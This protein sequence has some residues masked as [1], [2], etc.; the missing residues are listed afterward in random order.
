[1]LPLA[2]AVFVLA[3][4]ILLFYIWHSADPNNVWGKPLSTITFDDWEWLK[5][6]LSKEELDFF[7][8]KVSAMARD[9]YA[10]SSVKKVMQAFY[11]SK[12]REVPRHGF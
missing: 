10:A 5:G 6:K 12:L 11:E 2:I 3:L 9:E 1:M 7:I 8:E 4:V